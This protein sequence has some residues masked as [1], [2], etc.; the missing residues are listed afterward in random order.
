MPRASDRTVGSDV[1]TLT[2]RDFSVASVQVVAFTPDEQISGVKLSK[3]LLPMWSSRFDGQPVVL[4]IDDIAPPEVPRVILTS[5]SG[6]WRCQISSKRFEVIWQSRANDLSSPPISAAVRIANEY[7]DFLRARVGRLALVVTSIA[8]H[9]APGTFLARHFCRDEWLAAPFNRP[10]QFELHAHKIFS[11]TD[12]LLVN[13]WVR[14]RVAAVA[15]GQSS[16]PIVAV[17]QDLNTLVEEES[18]RD[19]RRRDIGEYFRTASAQA[20]SILRLYYPH[21]GTVAS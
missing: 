19:F 15:R 21:R 11:L 12:D 3:Q 1:R 9:D 16:R 2:Y 14:N 13:S 6:Q 20:R 18:K 17:E 4:P 5:K 10:A 8:E 7:R